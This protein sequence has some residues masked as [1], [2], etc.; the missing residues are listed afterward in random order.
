M[1]RSSLYRRLEEEGISRSITYTDI[2]N[3]ALDH[4]IHRIKLQ[5]SND[6]EC[7]KMGHLAIGIM[8]V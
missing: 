4:L 2:S 7:M 3:Q 5:H 1:N 8:F 6:G